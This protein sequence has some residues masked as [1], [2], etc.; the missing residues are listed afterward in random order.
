MADNNTPEFCVY[1][2]SDYQKAFWDDANRAYEDQSEDIAFKKLLPASGKRMLEIGAG[3]GRNTPRYSGYEKIYLFD[4]ALTQMQQAKQ[5]LG[6]SSRFVFAAADVY[7]LPYNDN[8]FDGATMIRVIHHLSE[9]D[10]AI[11]EIRRVM[12]KDSTFILEFANKRNIK[13]IL[14]WMTGKQKWNPFTKEQVEFVRLN[15]DN[16]PDT[17]KASLERHGFVIE[18]ALSVSNLRIGALKN[19][20][21]NLKWMLKAEDKMQDALSGIK[22]SP[23]V[24]LK[25]RQ[26]EGGSYDP[27]APIFKCP[28][29]GSVRMTESKEAVSCPDCGKVYP[30][31]DGIYNFRLD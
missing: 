4:Y 22:L 16:H 26:T 12:E 8:V 5:R 24:F 6:E 21:E 19:N 17:V 18:R 7:H 1:D 31:V 23:S 27:N 9:I 2:D 29:C 28:A 15:Y 13:A 25:C 30:I 11:A 3:A 14:R 10:P 20:P